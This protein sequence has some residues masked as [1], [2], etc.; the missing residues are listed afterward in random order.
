MAL[1]CINV[2]R[3]CNGCMRCRDDEDIFCPICD[4]RVDEILYVNAE[5]ETVGCENCIYEQR[6]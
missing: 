2:A 5:G 4:N 6:L 1:S 3:E